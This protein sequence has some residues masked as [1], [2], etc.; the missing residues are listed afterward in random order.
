MCVCSAGK[1]FIKKVLTIDISSPARTELFPSTIRHVKPAGIF[2]FYGLDGLGV[3]EV[4][5]GVRCCGIAR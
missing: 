1:G 4:S 2:V 5:R 3:D